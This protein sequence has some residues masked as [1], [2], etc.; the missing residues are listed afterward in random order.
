MITRSKDGIF[1]LKVLVASSLDSRH[2]I[3]VQE[4]LQHEKW[5]KAMAKEYQALL[6]NKLG[7]WCH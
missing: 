3:L 7:L 1:K 5:K 2:P 4:A 6:R